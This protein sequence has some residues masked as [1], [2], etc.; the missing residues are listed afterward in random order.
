MVILP[1]T[2]VEPMVLPVILKLPV[3]TKMPLCRVEVLVVVK[4]TFAIVLPE[5]VETVPEG[6]LMFIP[7]NMG[8]LERSV[9]AVPPQFGAVPPIKLLEIVNG[10]LVVDET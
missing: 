5:M 3:P 9:R 4:F 2:V 6:V 8:V 10:P 1:A 7:R